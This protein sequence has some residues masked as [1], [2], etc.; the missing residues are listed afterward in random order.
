MASQTIIVP[1]PTFCKG[2]LGRDAFDRALDIPSVLSA[3]VCDYLID[4]VIM[5][6]KE[7]LK[8][9]CFCQ[10]PSA[11]SVQ[12]MYSRRKMFFCTD[13]M[14]I[15]SLQMLWTGMLT[16]DVILKCG[17]IRSYP[18]RTTNMLIPCYYHASIA[19]YRD[20]VV[21]PHLIIETSLHETL[22]PHAPSVI[23]DGPTE[24]KVYLRSLRNKLPANYIP[25]SDLPPGIQ[26][27]IDETLRL[28]FRQ[29]T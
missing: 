9:R 5:T 11:V 13:H 14:T 21:G 1:D 4:N 8:E 22:Y 20:S 10:K 15:P 12:V 17:R 7:E 23:R 19:N 18:F 27:K 26:Q 25:I 2:G 29:R 28:R 16:W 3:L 24:V 6:V